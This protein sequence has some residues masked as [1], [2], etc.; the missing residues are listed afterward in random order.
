MLY[1]DYNYDSPFQFFV[2]VGFYELATNAFDMTH[3]TTYL[4]YIIDSCIVST[5]A[6][7]PVERERAK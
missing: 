7:D 4:R 6:F 5:L 3:V 1:H 2:P